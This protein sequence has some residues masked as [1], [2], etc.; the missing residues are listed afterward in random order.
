[1]LVCKLPPPLLYGYSFSVFMMPFMSEAISMTLRVGFGFRARIRAVERTSCFV[2]IR[3]IKIRVMHR[4][5]LIA[6]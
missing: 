1:M 3:Y 4:G 5:T 6:L 2:V